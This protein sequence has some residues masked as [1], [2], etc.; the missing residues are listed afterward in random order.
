MS[1][2]L[3]GSVTIISLLFSGLLGTVEAAVT[4]ISRA[5]VEQMA[6]DE[7]R[8]A[9]KSLLSVLDNR[10]QH[11]NFL[12]LGRTFLDAAAAVCAGMLAVQLME[13]WA[14]TAAIIGVTL[15]SFTIIGVFSRTVGRSNPYR[16]SLHSAVVLNTFAVI[17]GPL[18]KILIKIGNVIAPGPGFS[19]GPYSTEIEL[20]EMVDIAQEHGVVEVEER[21]MI[22]NVFDLA[23][24]TAREVMVPRPEMIWV[25]S[26]RTAGQATSLC[27]RSGHSRLP[28]IGETV[29]DIV[30]VVN[31]KDLVQ[32]TYYDTDGGKS[33]LVD[34]VMRDAK[35]IPDSKKLDELLH[36]MQVESFQ[37]ALLVDEFGGIAG[38]IS[39]ED[40]LEEIVGEITDEYDDSE[41]APVEVFADDPYTYR[42]V[43]RLL[44]EELA[45]QLQ[46][47]HGIEIEFGE[48][49][50]TVAGLIALEKGRVPLPGTTIEVN[51]LR[52]VAEGGRD[53][54]GR[55]R[56]L[57]VLVT[58][59]DELKPALG[60][61]DEA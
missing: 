35:F 59:L 41:V 22:Q 5:R 40:I 12:V 9:S 39:I 42:V 23:S 8:P 16:V 52:L 7:G 11:I 44:L 24:T 34:E 47:D 2:L 1:P 46:E 19:D 21:R 61:E 60:T 29:D 55:V 30:G 37:I 51:G 28:V 26:G 18:T 17:L 53:R 3:L 13:K 4:S 48:D 27:V 25:A 38:L 33:V 36:E 14:L 20:R 50:D 10:A 49:V 6:K 32:R 57:S 43:S 45:E 56:V 58:V 54:K 15:I 31:L